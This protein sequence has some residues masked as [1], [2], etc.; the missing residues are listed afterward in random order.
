MP[1]FGRGL[2]AENGGRQ[3]SEAYRGTRWCSGGPPKLVGQPQKILVRVES[4]T[5]TSSPITGSY[6]VI[7]SSAR[8]E[9]IG[10]FHYKKPGGAGLGVDRNVGTL[11]NIGGGQV[12]NLHHWGATDS[13]WSRL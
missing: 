13:R 5:C 9:D 2:A 4:W 7:G 11:E 3:E 10:F 12:G 1:Q 6:L 8:L